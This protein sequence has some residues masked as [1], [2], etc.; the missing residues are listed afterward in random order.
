M[1]LDLDT[2]FPLDWTVA[3]DGGDD[4]AVISCSEV[5]SW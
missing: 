1:E 2:V 3:T 4:E 5:L